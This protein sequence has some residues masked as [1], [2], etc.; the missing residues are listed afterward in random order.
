MRR[1][2]LYQYRKVAIERGPLVFALRRRELWTAV[3]GSE[4]YADYEIRTDEAWNYGL[5][6]QDLQRAEDAFQLVAQPPADQP[7]S[8]EA[9][10]LRIAARAR[11]I[12]DWQRYGG[13]AGPIPWSPIRSAEPD[14]TVTLVPYGC[15]EI[16]IA[17]FPVVV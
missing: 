17:E 1:K 11:R 9:A 5:L 7:W 16:R 14:E 12:P 8:A 2:F 6:D 13:M 15:T 3:K 10:P 4:P